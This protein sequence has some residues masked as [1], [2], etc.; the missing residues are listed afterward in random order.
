ML[1][2]MSDCM[3]IA[4]GHTLQGSAHDIAITRELIGD[5]GAFTE[6]VLGAD[7][8]KDARRVELRVLADSGF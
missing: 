6:G 5:L 7:P 2:A 8:P 3:V 4:I 1:M